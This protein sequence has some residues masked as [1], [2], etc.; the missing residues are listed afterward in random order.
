MRDRPQD[1]KPPWF[2]YAW[3]GLTIVLV[4]LII[5]S[6][7]S[8]VKSV[9]NSG[10]SELVRDH[11][12]GL[13]EEAISPAHMATVVFPIP[14]RDGIS[15]RFVSH[16]VPTNGNLP[17]HEAMEAL[18]KGPNQG[19]LLE[20]AV[21]FIPAGT[22]LI[23]LSVSNRIAYVDLSK[24]FLEDS[25]WEEGY[26]LR[27]GQVKRTLMANQSLRDVVILVEGVILE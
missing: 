15:Y 26:E 21:S 19:A 5:A 3:L 8:I 6:L 9:E 12:A 17:Y 18:L 25:A 23:G 2:L 11:L 1:H 20:G 10:M 4:L 27:S 22:E 14:D 7:P 24:E 16:T 13:Q